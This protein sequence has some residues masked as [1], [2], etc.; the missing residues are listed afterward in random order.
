[1]DV[2]VARQ[3]IFD[4]L[5]RIYAYEL[6]FRSGMD[7]AFPDLDGDTA[8]SSLLSSSFFT[9]G[10][11]QISG[12]NKVFINFTEDLLLRGTPAMFPPGNIMVEVLEDVNP[13]D[14][15]IA[16]CEDLVA[17]GYD[18]ALDDFVFTEAWRPLVKLAKI[19]K[20]DFMLMSIEEIKEIVATVKPYKC[21]LLAE[22]IETYKEF[23]QAKQMG[24]FY[25][26]GYFFSKPE[27]LKNKDIPS[28]QLSY[29]QLITEVAKAEFDVPSL[30]RLINQD[31]SV[32]YKLLKYL[33]SAYFS[34]LQPISSIRQAIAFLGERGVRQFVSLIAASKLSESKPTELIRISIIRARFLEQIAIDLREDNSGDFFMLGLFSLL[35][36]MLD[37]SM[38]YLMAQ[39][40][41]TDL[42]KNA[43]TKRQG[44]MFLFLQAIEQYEVGDWSSFDQ[45]ANAI[46]LDQGKVAGFYLDAVGWADSFQ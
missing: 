11:E 4:R 33:N 8:T 46:G 9:V 18:L 25:F 36:A 15:V 34:R 19:I 35:D 42:V 28:S 16:A 20:I 40:P 17:K 12:G 10:I 14:N 24:F 21:R 6:L 38:E 5:K 39:L 13:D 1:M 7:N 37:N 3:P 22:K 30:E 23:Q 43:L 32:S 45:T 41:L 29:F 44:N 26:Q 27:I 31:V 2:F